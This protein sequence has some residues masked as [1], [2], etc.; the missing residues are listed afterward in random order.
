MADF[1]T[2][3]VVRLACA[4][5]VDGSEAVVNVLHVQITGG[6]PLA[7]A[8]AA[9]DFQEYTQALYQLIDQNLP[10]N[11]TSDYVGV[12]NVTQ[13]TVWGS[14][15][16]TGFAAGLS[17]ADMLPMQTALLAWGRTPIT[18]VQIR[19]YLGPWTESDQTDGLWSSGLRAACQQYID[20][21]ITGQ[22]MGNGLVLRGCAYNYPLS[23]V[24]F[25]LTGTT[26]ANPVIQRRRRRG[27]GA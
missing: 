2:N 7:F 14:I 23:R 6:G 22:T 25:A 20:Y 17:V 1:E 19:K 16:W 3:D 8:A 27:R 5:Q 13:G 11:L 21:H 26:S 18:R 15:A 12:K 9:Q 24:T 10:N 4:M